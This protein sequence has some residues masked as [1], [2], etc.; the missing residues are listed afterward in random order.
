MSKA[1]SFFIKGK[2]LFKKKEFLKAAMLLEKSKKLEP[3]R[4]S[5]REF[6]A[7]SYYNLGFIE[8][9]KKNFL[10]ALEIDPCND[11]AHFGIGLCLARQ[12]N[13]GKALGHL[14]MALAMKPESEL[15]RN[16]LNKL[17]G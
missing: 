9:S 14:K 17:K 4:G 16:T 6:L 8:A 2:R 11:Y 15:Y 5:I 12:G 3:E 10:K 1:Y 13:I 7:A